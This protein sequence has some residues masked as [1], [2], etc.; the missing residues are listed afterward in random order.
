MIG[1]GVGCFAMIVSLSVMN[2][3]ESLVHDKLKGF[4]GDLRLEGNLENL[5]LINQHPEITQM[6]PFM[7]RRGVL[8]DG[9]DQKVVTLKAVET[10]TMALFYKM[11]MKGE[12]PQTGQVVLGQDLAYRLGKNVGDEV[13]IYSPIDQSFGIG[14]PPKLR[15]N[16]S[17]I[18]ATKVLDYDDKFVFMS[19]EDGEKL[20]RRKNGIDG[21]DIRVANAEKIISVKKSLSEM[22]GNDVVVQSWE[23]LNRSLV[24]AMKLE[25]LGTIVILSLIFLVAT[26]NLTASLSLISI[27][28]MKEIGIL[29]TMGASTKSIRKIIMQLGISQA[30]KG[31]IYGIL[32]GL[33]LVWIQN[34]FKLIPIPS[35]IYFIDALPMVL[36]V[37][38]VVMV[39]SISI[40][41]IFGAS[42]LSGIK[43]AKTDVKEAL[44]WTK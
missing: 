19:M 6:I 40:L 36:Y 31:L 2:G 15:L 43:M 4:E 28:K 9:G 21:I 16:V 27:Q 38:D 33:S 26:F 35:D 30:G 5:N 20:F 18:F 11:P 39:A 25:R 12:F 13:L 29:K 22:T 3:F 1:M 8:E 44:Q 7:E 10:S 32:F 41:F 42:F 17:G 24:E 34:Q 37:K 23:D 14:L